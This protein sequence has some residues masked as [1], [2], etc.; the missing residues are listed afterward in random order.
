MLEDM[1]EDAYKML[2][3]MGILGSITTQ[4]RDGD[5]EYTYNR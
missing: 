3:V 1:A 4:E 5:S 2:W